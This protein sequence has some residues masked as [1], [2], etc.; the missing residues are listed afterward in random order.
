[1]EANGV[2]RSLRRRAQHPSVIQGFQGVSES[3]LD[4]ESEDYEGLASSMIL[5]C[6]QCLLVIDLFEVGRIPQGRHASICVLSD[7][8]LLVLFGF[9]RVSS[10]FR[11]HRLVHVCQRWR[12]IVFSSP[13]GLDLQ[14]Y[15][16]PTTPVR[17]TLDCW[18]ALPIVVQC[19]KSPPAGLSPEEED[20]VVAALQ[21][22]DRV[23]SIELQLTSSL[24]EKLS[25]Q[26][27][28]PFSELEDLVLHFHWEFPSTWPP[29]P[30]SPFRWI[31]GSRLRVLHL[32]DIS[33]PSLPQLLS[34]S[35][36]LVD[37]RV[38]DI[39]PLSLPS[40]TTSAFTNSLSW[41]T[42]L[43][44]LSIHC[45]SAIS[46]L[47]RTGVPLPAGRR[48]VLPALRRLDFRGFSKYFERLVAGIDAPCLRKIKLAF[49]YFSPSHV[50]RRSQLGQ[51]INRIDAQRSYSR[52][53]IR[54]SA[55]YTS[56]QFRSLPGLESPSH[57]VLRIYCK[58]FD[59]QLSSLAR[60]CDRFPPFPS[61]YERPWNRYDSSV[62]WAR[63]C[64]RRKM[65]A[66]SPPIRQCTKVL[67][68]RRTCDR[69]HARFATNRRGVLNGA[70]CS[71]QPLHSNGA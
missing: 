45:L 28:E 69:H 38:H 52:A 12:R 19:R 54:T 46:F 27:N 49:I 71:A 62:K 25:T 18:P 68:G 70:T 35:P 31:S 44:S 21:H 56:V 43:E 63:R 4:S 42:R 60:V 66:S 32:T 47:A 37:L 55:N 59:K 2:D 65:A 15:C 67:C 33:L 50:D 48:V 3:D 36:N 16:T 6:V 34:S 8:V 11:W 26:V 20:N 10:P 58:R 24:G 5:S 53:E 23:R 40:F 29:F 1:M 64:G 9:Y 22:H 14:L 7:D 57:F 51:F 61:W 41:M 17:S 13:R 30:T 39:S